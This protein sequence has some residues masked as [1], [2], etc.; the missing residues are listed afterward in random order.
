MHRLWNGEILNGRCDLAR[1]GVVCF[2]VQEAP[3][4]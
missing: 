3:D 4:A 1:R 2:V